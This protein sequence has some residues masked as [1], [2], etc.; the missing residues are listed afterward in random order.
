VLK[1]VICIHTKIDSLA[2]GQNLMFIVSES[3]AGNISGYEGDNL[4]DNSPIV[5]NINL[6]IPYCLK[7]GYLLTKCHGKKLVGLIFWRIKMCCANYLIRLR[8]RYVQ[9]NVKI[10]S[11]KNMWMILII[12]IVLL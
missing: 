11:V 1:I 10:C 5:S 8:Y 3:L 2:A 12:I 7:K 4:S 9:Y 6:N